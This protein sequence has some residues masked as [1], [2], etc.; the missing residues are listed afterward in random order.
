MNSLKSPT[1]QQNSVFPNSAKNRLY[2]CILYVNFQVT[3][4][5]LVVRQ[6]GRQEVVSS[7]PGWTLK[8]L[9]RK[10]SIAL[11]LAHLVVTTKPE[12]KR[13]TEILQGSSYETSPLFSVFVKE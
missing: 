12:N 13:I 8:F 6:P 9:W 3:V 11:I 7:N 1:P 10:K 5:Q 4:D 2:F